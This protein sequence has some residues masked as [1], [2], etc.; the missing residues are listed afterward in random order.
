MNPLVIHKRDKDT[1]WHH[2][3]MTF[4]IKLD[5][6]SAKK[7]TKYGTKN[8]NP[9]TR[10]HFDTFLTLIRLKKYQICATS[11]TIWTWLSL[12]E[13]QRIECVTNRQTEEKRTDQ[14]KREQ[15]GSLALLWFG[16]TPLRL[17][18]I[19][20]RCNSLLAL[21]AECNKH[22]IKYVSEAVF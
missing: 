9:F 8:V 16:L 18:A 1:F 13:E 6:K 22:N 2:F 20:R 21:F 5:L 11:F 4:R 17:G 19:F 14:K 12:H 7:W 3:F 10:R 15:F